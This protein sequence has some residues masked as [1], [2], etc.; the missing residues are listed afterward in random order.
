MITLPVPITDHPQA[1]RGKR[2][3]HQMACAPDTTL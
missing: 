3:V 1:F 2:Q